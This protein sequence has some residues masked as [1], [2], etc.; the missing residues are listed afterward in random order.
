MNALAGR[1][2]LVTGASGGIGGALARRLATAGVRLALGYAGHREAA[3]AL[4]VEIRRAGG[5][6]IASGA[7][8]SRAESPAAQVAEVQQRLGQLDIL[9]ANAGVADRREWPDVTIADFDRAL[10]VNLRAPVLAAQAALPGM[11]ER[12]FGRVLFVSSV[13][14]FTGGIVGPH[15]AASKAGLHAITAFLSRRLA[16]EGVTVNA[17]APA[18]IED[19]RMFAGQASQLAAMIPAGRLGRSDEVAALAMAIL[20]NGYMTGQVV[21]IDGGM[22][23]R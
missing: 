22:H 16:R 20:E 15:Y 2:A 19:T 11:V 17:I 23:P 12:K 7:D 21:G 18:L 13:A 3:E 14:A 8:L 6:A 5:E 1:V 9:V 10:A 4:A